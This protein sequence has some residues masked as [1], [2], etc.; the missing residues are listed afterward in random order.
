MIRCANASR[1]GFPLW[2][3]ALMALHACDVGRG[4]EIDPTVVLPHPV[5]IV[6]GSGSVIG[7]RVT[8]YHHVTIGQSRGSY[9]RI[10]SDV[11]LYPYAGVFGDICVG[12]EARV[13]AARLIFRDLAPGEVVAAQRS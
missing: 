10:E 3:T 9:P 8:I 1:L 4:A 13:G 12:A 11:T 5:G 6:I 2:R 7:A